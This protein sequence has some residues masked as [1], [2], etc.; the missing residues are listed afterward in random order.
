MKKNNLTRR[1]FLKSSAMAGAFGVIGTTSSAGLLTS[2]SGGEK[3]KN[4]NVALK[5]PGSYYIPEL[6]DK[7]ADGKELKAGVIGCGGRG[8]G[9]TFNFLNA[10]NG[11][12]IVALGD[13]FQERVDSLAEK[14]KTEKNI[15]IPT[16]KRFVGLDAY[17]QVIDSGVDVIIDATPPFFRPEHFK[18]AVEKGKHCFL[19]KP[20]C[21]DPVGY[22]T[23]IAAAKQ[24]QAKNLC[25]VTGTQRHHQ[26]SYVE[27]YKKIMEGAIGEITGGVVYWNQGMLWYRERQPG[28][29]DFEYMIRD[30][31]N[32]KWL[33]GDHIVEQHVHNIDVFTWFTGL[34]PISAVGFGSRHRRITG[35]QYDNFS[36]DFTMENGI[37]F[38]SMCRQI[39]G[40]ANNVSEFIQGTKGSWTTQG[41]TAIRDL[42]GNVIWKY[43][44]EAEKTNFSQTDPYT[45]E[46][47]NLINCI[48]ANKPIEQ[49]SET[50]IAN[51]AAIMG[52]ESAYTGLETKWDTM[53]ASTLDYT[54]KDLNMGKMDMS[55]FTVP[56]PGKPQ[57]KKG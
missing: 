55:A 37:H 50:A 1:T 5:E 4:G 25:V 26:R 44:Y 57:E 45:L 15:D 52:R 47:V 12:T 48:R 9:A 16:D 23:I 32:W 43:D 24:A 46:H 2:C 54:P 40:C 30:W 31:V 29:S 33:S 11:V 35:D 41:E 27:S 38:H 18:Y 3:S 14:L 34:K 22:R 21:V 56:V 49:A 6:S 7:A 20:I 13:V 36:I 8:S 17:K 39:D 19:E 51:M 10:A 53:T 28:W 42:A